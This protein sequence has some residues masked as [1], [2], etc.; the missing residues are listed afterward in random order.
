MDSKKVKRFNNK[1]TYYWS[2]GFY[3]FFCV[4]FCVCL[5]DYIETP[6]QEYENH[7]MNRNLIGSGRHV[8]N[9][10][11]QKFLIENFGAKGI[12]VFLLL[13]GT[14]VFNECY[15]TIKEYRRMLFR[16]KQIRE[17]LRAPDDYIDDYESIPLR[18]R[19]KNIFSKRNKKK[20]P[21]KRAMRDSL[22][23]NKYYKE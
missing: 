17:G 14:L 8:R 4:C 23:K 7:I 20:Y 19:L 15:K 21:S 13:V 9:I 10:A 1:S 12:L 6:T 5:C 11:F 18:K 3:I 16:E 22:K 2:F